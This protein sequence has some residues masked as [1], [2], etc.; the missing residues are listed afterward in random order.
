MHLKKAGQLWKKG[1]SIGLFMAMFI[2]FV[3]A[4]L[5]AAAEYPASVPALPEKAKSIP[6]ARKAGSI[7]ASEDTLTYEQPFAPFTA[8][9]ENFRIP[10][11][12]SLRYSEEAKEE[13]EHLFAA[14]DA[15]WEEW[16]DGGGIDSMASVSS[17]G[18]KT[19]NYSFPIYF[20]DSYGYASRAATTVIDPGAIEGPDGTIYF[21]ADVNP[22]GSTTMYGTVGQGTG[23]VTV[24][25]KRY[26]ALTDNYGKV[27]TRPTDTNLTDYPYYVGDFNDEGYAEILKRADSTST[28][29]G[30]D[31]WY[32]IYEIE[33]GEYKDTLTQPQVNRADVEVQQNC[34]YR[35]SSYHVYHI[36]Y[37][38][39]VKSTDGGRTWEHPR[40][41]TDQIKREGEN[42]ILVSPGKGIVTKDGEIAIGLYSAQNGEHASMIYTIDGENWERTD[43]IADGSSEDEIVQLED[44]TLRMFYRGGGNVIRYA[45]FTKNDQGTY[46]VGTYVSTN[47]SV[48]SSINVSAVLYSKK[49]DGKQVILVARSGGGSGLTSD[50]RLNGKIFTFLVDD[51]A[52]GN[53]MTLY[54]TFDVPGGKDGFVYSCMTEMKDGRIAM[55]WE[56]N[57]STLYYDVYD[58]E[59]LIGNGA[60]DVELKKDGK[61]YEVLCGEDPEI[62]KAEDES[63]INIEKAVKDGSFLRDHISNVTSS[64]NSFASQLNEEIQIED[65]E[66]T[67]QETNTANSWKIYNEDTGLYIENHDAGNMFSSSECTMTVT[68]E[69]ESDGTK[70][71][72]IKNGARPI[73]FYETN[74]D[75]NSQSSDPGKPAKMILLE[76]QNVESDQDIIPGYTRASEVTD[77]GKYLITYQWTDNSI[78]VLYPVN[79]GTGAHTKLAAVNPDVILIT[80]VEE[81]R[82]NVTIDGVA[83]KINVADPFESIALEKGEDYFV[84]TESLETVLDGGNT[85]GIEKIDRIKEGLFDHVADRAF[86]LDGYAE[87]VNEDINLSDAEFTFTAS[88]SNWIVSHGDLY[89]SNPERAN[90]FFSEDS[91][92]IKATA[93]SDNTFRL[94]R[95]E[96]LPTTNPNVSL[97]EDKGPNSPIGSLVFYYREMNFR[98]Y[99]TDQ[100]AGTTHGASPYGQHASYDLKLLEKQETVSDDDILPGYQ[101]V[102]S[103]T[104]EKQ[105]LISYIWNE[106]VFVLYPENGI[107]NSTKLV[108]PTERGF[109]ITAKAAG[110]ADI[111][112]DD[113]TYHF[114]VRDTEAEKAKEDLETLLEKVKAEY[115]SNATDL[116]SWNAFKEAYAAA[117]AY[118]QNTEVVETEKL[119]ELFD[120]VKDSSTKLTA[121]K[122]KKE[123]EK[124]AVK[125]GDSQTIDG[126]SYVV[127]DTAKKTVVVTGG[128]AANMTIKS[129]VTFGKDTYTVTEIAA[130][131]FASSNTLKKIT[132]GDSV[133]SIGAQAFAGCKNLKSVVIGKDVKTIGKKAFYNCKKLS[134]VTVKNKSKLSKVGGS[135]FKKTAKSIKIKLPKNLKKNSKLK[136]QL[137]KAGIKK[138]L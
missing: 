109:K 132:I 87:E 39:V 69:T 29:F 134:K 91:A 102:S 41:I 13:G 51:T 120:K 75:F 106:H 105:Y 44:G 17:D 111:V 100:K 60:I 71:F 31:E 63:V 68:P 12:I 104:S 79:G 126:V 40:D 37:I 72:K 73:F 67:F 24:N 43:D 16:N 28:G 103:I 64:L 35:D 30:V 18:G 125:A 33:N 22:T 92:K 42:A 5:T 27:T 96:A 84:P 124:N 117:L 95:A 93:G 135:A 129:A 2:S 8:G 1:I 138:G 61:P 25:N 56:P 45:D 55:L 9:N 53:P 15:R 70:T 14:A 19:W 108:N 115:E 47:V 113:V 74:M 85:L 49:I 121:E 122:V 6:E 11:L 83:Y 123:N 4:E 3:P 82:T 107:A 26:L 50:S 36:D 90:A 131:A 88:D 54:H 32:N 128:S 116:S 94:A 34:F 89:L 59:E 137:K 78:F 119:Q 130:K 101:A 127:T 38:W 98:S 114:T 62:L 21:I 23:Y 133:E 48:K 99:G 136:K 86:S 52:K 7:P 81:G 80:G 58:F 20:P 77:G 46:D 118:I 66:F 97:K 112:I 57:H 65:A 110:E 10:T 76:K